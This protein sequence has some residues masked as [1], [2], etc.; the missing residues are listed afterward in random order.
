MVYVVLS[1]AGPAYAISGVFDNREDAMR[2]VDTFKDRFAYVQSFRL[3]EQLR[4]PLSMFRV[5]PPNEQK[6]ECV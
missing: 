3:N 1:A 5:L 6:K 2:C 4:I